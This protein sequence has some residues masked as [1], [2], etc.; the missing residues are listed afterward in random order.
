MSEEQALNLLDH[1][2]ELGIDTLD[3]AISYGPAHEAISKSIKPFKIHTKINSDMLT[4]D[5]VVSIDRQLENQEVEVIY[6]HDPDAVDQ[7][8]KIANISEILKKNNLLLGISIYTRA[9]FIKAIKNTDIAAIQIPISVLNRQIDDVLR[10]EAKHAGKLIVGRSL[11]LQGFL[12][13]NWKKMLFKI[14]AL[15]PFLE[16]IEEIATKYKIDIEQCAIEWILNQA[17][18]DSVI[19]GVENTVQLD[20]NYAYFKNNLNDS[21]LINELENLSLPDS[22]MV[23]PRNWIHESQ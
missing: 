21:D 8:D 12:T 1:A 16:V 5:A 14:H 22:S 20:K 11:F 17:Y 15:Q 6:L 9:E 7:E 2:W 4:E 10:S 18:L 23:D 3:T 19:I 13:K